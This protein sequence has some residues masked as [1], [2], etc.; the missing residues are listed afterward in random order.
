LSSTRDINDVYGAFTGET[1][2]GFLFD[3]TEITVK[4]FRF[5]KD[6]PSRSEAKRVTMNL[7]NFHEIA[8]DFSNVQTIGQGFADE[9]FRVWQNRYPDIRLIATNANENVA[10]MIQRAGGKLNARSAVS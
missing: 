9:I 2:D 5:G 4:L 7:E 3:K 8:F 1:E 6:L 10:F